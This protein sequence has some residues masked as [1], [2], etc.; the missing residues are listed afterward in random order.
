M[1]AASVPEEYTN[2]TGVKLFNKW[3]F[4]DVEITDL[5]LTVRAI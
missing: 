1:A 3:S 2:E 5:A 4:D